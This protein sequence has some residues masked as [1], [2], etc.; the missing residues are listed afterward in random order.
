[1]CAPFAC[2]VCFLL[3]LFILQCTSLSKADW[4]FQ[5]VE[6]GQL[7]GGRKEEEEEKHMPKWQQ[8]LMA[9]AIYHNQSKLESHQ[10]GRV[11]KHSM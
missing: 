1:M 4:N 7:H 2:L 11:V 6:V 9:P 5:C 10:F 3:S 8:F